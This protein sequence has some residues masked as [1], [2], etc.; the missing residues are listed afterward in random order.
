M[1]ILFRQWHK[2]FRW[3][4]V[5]FPK[6][7]A[8]ISGIGKTTQN[9]YILNGRTVPQKKL[10]G[11]FHAADVD[12]GGKCSSCF[13]A[14]HSWEMLG[15]DKKVRSDGFKAK[16]RMVKIQTDIFLNLRNKSRLPGIFLISERIQN[17]ITSGL[18]QLLQLQSILTVLVSV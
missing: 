12:I 13:L 15:I 3:N 14:K 10:S 17:R 2:I 16:I 18:D 7:F 9:S 8:E 4:P 5:V 11:F 1:T 6:A